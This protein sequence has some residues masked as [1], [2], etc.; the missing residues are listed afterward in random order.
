MCELMF[1]CRF[2]ALKEEEAVPPVVR[3]MQ[4]TLTIDEINSVILHASQHKFCNCPYVPDI[5]TPTPT[6][7]YR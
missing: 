3:V 1:E 4:V 5:R 7:E 2:V 6:P